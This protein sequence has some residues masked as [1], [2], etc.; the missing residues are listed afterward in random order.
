MIMKKV[1]IVG[2]GY[3]GKLH[4]DILCNK[5][6]NTCVTAVTDNVEKKGRDLADKTGAVYYKDFDTMV[7]KADA[8]VIAICTPTFLHT[9]MVIKAAGAKK[10]IFCEKPLALSVADAEKMITAVRD[11]KVNVMA[12]HVLRFWPVYVRVKEIIDSKEFGKAHHIYCERLVAFP[13]WAESGW[14]K[15]ETLGGGGGL[16]VQIHDI[17]YIISILGKPA[18]V[19]AQGTYNSAFGG[20]ANMV[21]NMGFSDGITGCVQAGWGLPPGF[22]FTNVLRVVCENG[23][24][25]WTFR[26]GKLLEKRDLNSPM[27][28][29]KADGTILEET[30]D[31][32][33]AFLIQWKYFIDCLETERK[34]E[35]ATFEDGRNAL[36]V[37]LAAMKSAK[38]GKTVKI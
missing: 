24:I 22:P 38:K 13:D 15:K 12:G 17:D 20:W 32:T 1:A 5:I 6:E 31:D 26:A 10:D 37:V 21:T 8:D 18:L 34:I 30:P 27:V 36:E 11:N 7:L 9:E 28:I 4:A 35:N 19:N 16:D 25:E 23:T 14:N 2:A 29:Y 3:I 33:D